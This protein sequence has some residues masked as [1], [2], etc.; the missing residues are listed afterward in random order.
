MSSSPIASDALSRLAGPWGRHALPADHSLA[1]RVGPRELWL[2][3]A[4]GEIQVAQGDALA[5]GTAVRPGDQRPE[6]PEEV[7]WSRWATPQGETEVDLRPAL[8]DR[9]VV[10]KPERAFRLLPRAEARVY[11][12]VPLWVRIELP[13]ASGGDPL[14]LDEIPSLAM[15]DTWWGD[16]MEGE[17][18]YWLPTTAR[19]R[20][21]PELQLPHLAACSL[22]LVNRS[23][24]DLRVEKLSFRVAHLSLFVDDAGR[25]WGE[26]TRVTYRGE[27]ETSQV[28]MSGSAPAEAA[29]AIRVVPPRSPIVKGFRARTFDRLRVLP[30]MG[31]QG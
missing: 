14:L 18:T 2:R 11:V 24:E 28:E 26:E 30:G 5:P 16:F 19:R 7:E 12:R 9:T 1:I 6:P 8:P 23:S 21:R 27:A 15:S 17:L 20:M 29:G 13:P 31:G 3:A 25:L 22:Q 4:E 10:L